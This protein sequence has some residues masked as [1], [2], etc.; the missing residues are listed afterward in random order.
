MT[1][2]QMYWITRLDALQGD[3]VV[4]IIIF[5]FFLGITAFIIATVAK[6]AGNDEDAIKIAQV[7]SRCSKILLS[8]GF[9][10]ILLLAFVPS[11]KEMAAI[12]IVPKIVNNEKIQELPENL[13]ELSNEWIKAKTKELKEE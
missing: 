10:L 3:G 6:Y 11:T 9:S 5:S 13:L 2:W 4:V 12:I 7:T 1:H 8:I